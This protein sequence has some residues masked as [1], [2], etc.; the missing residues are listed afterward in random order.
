MARVIYIECA[1]GAAGDML[2]GALVDAGVPIDPLRSA[3]GTLGVAHVLRASR[4][5]RAGIAAT[6]LEVVEAHA[7]THSEDHA[8]HHRHDE[9]P[10]H[11]DGRD[12]GHAAGHHHGDQ[13]SLRDI[14]HLIGHS[15]LSA[16]GKARAI[17]LFRTLGAA[18]AAIHG[19][20]LEAIH[21]HEVGA[22]DSI[23]DIV[24]FVFAMEW[25]GIDDV[26]ASPLNVGSGTVEI[27]HGTFPVPAPATAR[28][29]TGV[30]I[31]SAGPAVELVTPTGALLVA[32][33]AR[34]YGPAP[35]MTIERIGYGAGTRDFTAVPNVVRVLIG[36][37]ASSE[38]SEPGSEWIVKIECEI[39]DM[40]P[41]WFG[42]AGERLF[43]TGALDVFLTAVQ[44][45]KGRP[46]TLV[47]V[48]APDERRAAL[49]DVLFRET[50]TLGVRFERMQRETLDR[51]F[52]EVSTS[53][54]VVRIKVAERRGVRV[55]A[56][57]E[58]E[59]CLR[60]ARET[61]RSV[62]E[63]QAEALEA[64]YAQGG[65]RVS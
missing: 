43:D 64:W 45:K 5:M 21:F 11:D 6:R 13:R 38:Q 47:T 23:I 27:A 15:A 18:E 17:D 16:A 59:D 31:Y 51:R 55:N 49:C 26:V 7:H 39:D 46:G 50:T 8:R 42:P 14:E 37:R 33:Y 25:L 24:G 41:Q 62:K 9:R 54:G 34:A 20:P 58:F 36:E 12:H 60:I 19:V 4:V 52:V 10:S 2:L 48:L 3:L 65:R 22:I 1:S 56:I 30:P 63:V 29:L 44:M 53:S 32:S 57:P 35:A 61:G 28:L 40:N